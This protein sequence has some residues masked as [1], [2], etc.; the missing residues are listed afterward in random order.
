M[1]IAIPLAGR[2]FMLAFGGLFAVV[3]VVLAI[4][5]VQEVRRE[6]AYRKYGEA[7]EAVVV[8]KT[9]RRAS[10]EGNTST[11]YEVRYRFRA[12]DGR[13]AEGLES[14]SVET[15]E[16]LEPGSPFRITYLPGAETSR[17]E[18]ADVQ[19]SALVMTAL[20]TVFAV[21]GGAV[22][23]TTGTAV[24]REHR[25]LRRGRKASGTILTIEA[26]NVAVNR[27]RQW[28]LRYRYHDHLGRAHEGSSGP[29]PPEA[30]QALA[31]GDTV[32]IR[33][34]P[35]RPERSVWD[36][37]AAAAAEGSPAA[38]SRRHSM[39][40]K[41]GGLAVML[42]LIF[43]ALVLGEAIP[44]LKDFERFTERHQQPLLLVTA[45]TTTVG[46]VLFMGSILYRIFGGAGEPMTHAEI[47]DLQRGVR[48]EA[49]PVAGRVAV[50]RFRGRSAGASFSDAFTLREAKQAWR[51][52][53]WRTS[54]R[55]RANF[56][57]LAGAALFVT[58]MFGIVI[59]LGPAGIKLL[60]GAAALYAAVMIVSATV[61]A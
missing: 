47:E 49:R 34:D 15:W 46:F 24:W 51:Q 45:V 7:V 38:V 5:G 37:R 35:E 2:S 22:L 57:V 39:A 33:F 53:A 60:F 19:A 59:V 4:T 55:W 17:A 56:A 8:D 36:R 44:A 54:A 40:R 13:L 52:R 21:V 27:V 10:R 20:G 30:V 41:V 1:R 14:V 61:R 6:Q 23:A 31:V 25:L 3:G 58:G 48:L 12:A 42:G 9:I 26:S 11:R 43:V 28:R 18:G 32:S 29:V 50:Y 16:S